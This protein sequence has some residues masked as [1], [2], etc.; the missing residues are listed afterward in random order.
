VARTEYAGGC[1]AR[2]HHVGDIEL[3]LEGILAWVRENGDVVDGPTDV[4]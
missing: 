1:G 4:T 2:Q 3:V